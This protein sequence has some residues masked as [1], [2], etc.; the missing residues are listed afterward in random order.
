M[1]LWKVPVVT[2]ITVAELARHID[3]TAKSIMCPNWEFR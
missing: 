1:K 2:T 3:L